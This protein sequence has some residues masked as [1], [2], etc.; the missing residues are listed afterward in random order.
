MN[1]LPNMA[2]RELPKGTVTFLFTDIEGSTELLQRLRDK[3]IILLEDHHRI[4]RTIFAKWNG[5]EVDTEGDAFFV[6]FPRATEAIAAVVEA[7]KA[8]ANH[9]W[10]EDVT[11]R[12]RM[13]LHTGEPWTGAEGYVGMDVHRAA[14]I[15]HV[16]H[17]GQVLLSET[18]AALVKSNLPANANLIDLGLHRLKDMEF[19]EHIRQLSMAGLPSE[20]PP[21]N[22]IRVVEPAAKSEFEPP[23]FPPYLEE[24]KSGPVPSLFVGRDRELEWLNQ[25]L[26]DALHN[27]GGIVFVTG[28]AGIGKSALLHSMASRATETVSDLLVTWGTG[29]AL[30]GSGDAYL[31]FRQALSLLT[32]D[33]QH[34]WQSGNITTEQ[35]RR[36]WTA[37]PQ[38]AQVIAE[39][40]Q[41]I[42]ITLVDVRAFLDRVAGGPTPRFGWHIQLEK[43]AG[44]V[45]SYQV[46]FSQNQ[47]YQQSTNVLRTLS[48]Q[49]PLLILLDDL[50][51][52][53][54]ASLN[55]LFHLGR[56]LTDCRILIIGSFRS[57][58]VALGRE[59]ARH[60]LEKVVAELRRLKGDLSLDLEKRS[61]SENKDFVEALL[62]GEPNALSQR[63][64]RALL[65]HTNGQPLFTVEAL[66]N[67]QERGDLVRNQDGLWTDNEEVA[68]DTLPH[69]VEGIIEERIDRLEP[70]LQDLLTIA[71]VEGVLFTTQVVA[72]V[73]SQP[74][75]TLMRWLSN[76]LERRHRL[77]KEQDEVETSNGLLTHYRFSHALFR[78]YLY[79]RLGQGERRLLHGHVAEALEKYYRGQLGEMAV[80]LAHHYHQA[81]YHEKAFQYFT[82]AAE[83]AAHIFASSE[84]IAN[85]TH[86]IQLA[87]KVSIDD[88]S[89]A[90]LY[91]GRGQ[92]HGLVGS[93]EQARADHEST[94][95]IGRAADEQEVVWRS[96][97][98]LGR[99]WASRDY[100]HAREFFEE[101]LTLARRIEK[102]ELLAVSLNWMGNWSANNANFIEAV[103]YHQEALAIFENLGDQRELAN[104]LDLLGVANILGGDLV[105]GA[106]YYDRAIPLCQELDDRPR[107]A[108][109][110]IGRATTFSA[111]VWMVT[112]SDTPQRIAT[113]D[114][115]E[116]RRIA[117]EIGSVSEEIWA[118]W[119]SGLMHI[120]LG[121]I[122]KALEE[123]QC[124]LDT[125]V[126]IGH[127][128]WEVGNRS[129]LGLLY[130][131]LY[132][133]SQ[134]LE[135]LERAM[136]LAR[137]LR[138]PTWISEVSGTLAGVYLMQGDDKMAQQSLDA[139]IT[140]H[141]SMDTL[142]KR[143]CWLRRAE[144]A[145]MQ[146]DH[147]YALEIV[148]RL[149]AAAAGMKPGR[150][151]SYLW[152]LRG[153][154][155][156]TAGRAEDAQVHLQF[157]IENARDTG[158]RFLEWKL[159]ASLGQLYTS[160]QDLEAADKECG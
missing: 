33:V 6:S 160:M 143:F 147:L 43:L 110:L 25:K 103:A 26:D 141:S 77:V 11:V 12:V 65:S 36:L 76:D 31:P 79:K 118:H 32:G 68:W 47:L 57:E 22:S 34:S 119:S 21:L 40:G 69:R 107:L 87:E 142:S 122:G 100:E 83:S 50:Q 139:A 48:E 97:L 104:T 63:F 35:A 2:D 140:V 55:L 115:L 59:G 19:T 82:L 134:A 37:M 5:R 58:E 71:S 3:Y 72:D 70:D 78:D 56:S 123:L 91:H 114:I 148:D 1:E 15:A 9:A 93:F 155:L 158:E 29:N 153:E 84:A 17:G 116:A 49:R 80:Q 156:G 73:Q 64:R 81:R 16:G 101:A 18:T 126:D 90:K 117:K 105:T 125:A 112:V 28:E 10:P 41:A 67:L 129:A 74:E 146:D 154:A 14:R 20:F 152:K 113:A 45:A 111:G 109:S 130:S 151:I 4:L 94:L 13:G 157:A 132:A 102:K 159:H 46:D 128:E 150:I 24:G 133:P 108:S 124:G 85:F 92:S 96:L 62:D 98:D 95:R 145:L 136:T 54:S 60:P 121:Q 42:A 89:L 27:K 44:Q 61:D 66:S 39:K 30:I 120:L 51:W 88:V 8:L 53:D 131:G 99:L 138:S 135:H 86:A 75:R 137:E 7:Q 38:T 127:R 144:L 106:R 23:P 52:A 149:I